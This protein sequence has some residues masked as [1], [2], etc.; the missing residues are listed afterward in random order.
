MHTYTQAAIVLHEG[1]TKRIDV[2]LALANVQTTVDVQADILN[3]EAVTPEISQTIGESDLEELPSL[4][5]SATKYA[6]LD[7]HVRQTEGLG[8]DFT[9]TNRLSINAG[10]YRH[11][12][13][14]LDGT[15]TYDW[16][17]ANLPQAVVSPGS[18]AEVKVL[19]GDYS[20]QYGLSTNGII[21]MTTASGTNTYHGEGF[22]YLRPSGIQA[23]PPVATFH[24]P[25]EREDWGLIFGGPIQKDR[26]FFFANYERIEQDRGSYIQSPTPSFFNGESSEY[27]GLFR[28]DHNFSDNNTLT[29]RFNGHHYT[30]NDVDDRVSGF[31]QP[32]YGRTARIQSWGGQ[33]SDRASIGNAINVARFAFTD[34]FPDGGF[35]LD[36][37]VQVVRPNYST[38]GF[39]TT[40][41][42]H[43][44]TEEGS[45]TLAFLH[46][47]HDIKLGGEIVRLDARDYSNTPFGTYTFAPGPPQPGENPLKYSQTFGTA[48]LT[49]GQTEL[50]AFIQDDIRITPRVTASLGLR[51]EFQSITDS[52][53]NLGPRIGIA[54]DATGDGKTMVRF[55]GGVFYD[56]YY[57]YLNRRFITLGPNSPQA[58]YTWNW[59]D[60]GFP[61][62]PDPS[63]PLPTGG[64]GGRR[65][66]YIPADHLLNPYSL[67]FSATVERQLTRNTVITISGLNIHTLHQMRV[68]DINHPAPFNRTAPGQ[69]RSTSDADATRPYQT[70]DG[71]AVRDIAEIDNTAASIYQSLDLGLTH[72]S[73]RWGDFGAH[74][75]FAGSY[76]Y[77]MFYADAN[78]GIPSEWWPN[79]DAYERGPSDFYQRHRFVGTAV[80]RLPWRSELN[81]VAT[82]GSGLP[83]N[84]ITGVDN[85]GDSYTVDRPIGLGRNSFRAPLQQDF[86]AAVAKRFRLLER[87]D[88]QARFQVFNLFNHNN[89]IKLNNTFG[90]GP[91]PATTWLAPI[92]G[93]ANVDPGRQFEFAV[94]LI[95]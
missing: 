6:L 10:S 46:G 4:V 91:A 37:S 32:S 53:H 86:D 57:M 71:L 55:G 26:T 77:S 35:P 85:N 90:E 82:L 58:T 81:L 16:V 54:W 42:V 20:A 50:S 76:T 18:V 83:V 64:S 23:L 9:G 60:P 45:D 2:K 68:N 63:V 89:Y 75:V 19:A 73:K 27:F 80:T 33:V 78:S 88:L 92:A 94:R 40:N 79:W 39:S 61:V 59:G 7:P 28:L 5:R 14:M 3:L 47:R 24:I 72:R 65:D 44:H 31:F 41:W 21:A 17:Y 30:S 87:L 66:L 67:Q 1:E 8:A 70:F 13:F 48:N 56:Q 62:F 93:I 51:Y 15:S 95:F 52:L 43:A 11:T 29:A 74:Y 69:V 36:P 12:G 34:Y 84:P 25:N 22:A 38:S 49:Y